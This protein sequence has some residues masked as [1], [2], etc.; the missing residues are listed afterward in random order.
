MNLI[1]NQEILHRDLKHR[2]ELVPVGQNAEL[3]IALSE[4]H[5]KTL[6]IIL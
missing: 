6:I 5:I 3:L 2:G 1:E 4:T